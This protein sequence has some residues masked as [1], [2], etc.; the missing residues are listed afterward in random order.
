MDVS[1]H[2]LCDHFC[3]SAALFAQ[4]AHKVGWIAVFS[5]YKEGFGEGLLWRVIMT[6]NEVLQVNGWC[7]MIV[8]TLVIISYVIIFVSV[9]LFLHNGLSKFFRL[10]LFVYNIKAFE[11]GYFGG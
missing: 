6:T 2:F 4:W 3:V 1:D 9:L 5:K 8:W 10:Q 11:W 7:W